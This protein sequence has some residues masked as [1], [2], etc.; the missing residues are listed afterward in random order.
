MNRFTHALNF[1]PGS[2]CVGLTAAFLLLCVTRSFGQ[3]AEVVNFEKAEITG[4]GL[5]S[6]EEKGV[7]FTPAH[8]PTKSKAKAR[9]MFFPHS[10]D[11]K[12]G[13]VNAMADDPIPVRARFPNGSSSVAVQFWGSTGCAAR[14]EA[15]DADGKLLDTAKLE[16]APARKSPGDP[17]PTFELT[18]KGTNIAYIE[19]SGPRPSEF[20]VADEV[21][22][23][24]LASGK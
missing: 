13:I 10:P 3:E 23:V 12:K 14:L 4:H 7:V 8:E 2:F 1:R 22:F 18:V 24:P 21:R 20:L 17:V 16:A 9:V 5:P 15:Y 6:W 11:G 19:F